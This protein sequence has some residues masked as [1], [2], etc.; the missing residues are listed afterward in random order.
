MLL[1]RGRL[2]R[3]GGPRRRRGGRSTQCVAVAAGS[4]APGDGG[5]LGFCVVACNPQGVAEE[6]HIRTRRPMVLTMVGRSWPVISKSAVVLFP[7]VVVLIGGC[8]SSSSG[9][10]PARVTTAGASTSAASGAGTTSGSASASRSPAPPLLPE[11][12]KHPTRP[13]AEAFF[14]YFIAVYSYSYSSQNTS[15]LRAISDVTCKFC[16]S[17]I[18]AIE[19][20]RA[21]NQHAVG[22]DGVVTNV[23]AAPG[24]PTDGL[25]INAV[26]D[27]RPSSIVDSDGSVIDTAAAESRVRMDAAVRWKDGAWQMRGLHVFP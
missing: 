14:R 18:D 15:S 10:R 4:V 11:A 12:A 8:T 27:Q 16:T 24:V 23:V 25:L 22:G 17:A 2:C 19:S 13:G 7:V 20:T 5:D 6:R 1:R 9:A 3:W 26:V 21:D